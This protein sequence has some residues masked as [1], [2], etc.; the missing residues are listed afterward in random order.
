M[1]P[2]EAVKKRNLFRFHSQT[3]PIMN[4]GDKVRHVQGTEEGVVVRMLS[5]GRVEVEI[6]DGFRVPFLE[7]QL[8]V[9]AAAERVFFGEGPSEPETSAKGQPLKAEAYASQGLYLAFVPRNDRDLEIHVVNNTDLELLFSLGEEQ[10]QQYDGIAAGHLKPRSSQKVHEANFDRFEQWAPLVVQAIRFR[11]GRHAVQEPLVKK[12][13]WKASSFHKHRQAAPLLGG[14]AYLFQLDAEARVL[15]VPSLQDA[16]N[17]QRASVAAPADAQPVSPPVRRG[18]MREVDL[19]LEAIDP[20]GLID[21]K[22]ALDRQLAYFEET[23]DQAIL[24]GIDDM[25]FIHGVGNGV[26]RG[27][28]H[29]LLSKHPHVAYFKDARKEKFG[30]GATQVRLK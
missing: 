5:G 24:E 21:R 1:R 13:R 4:I 14:E 15:D 11:R 29:A 19:H 16:L 17:E 20:K 8:V 27:K 10:Q 3:T 28:I 7:R 6:E 2:K 9:V 12:L 26:L 18:G 22:I 30:F 25:V 23:L